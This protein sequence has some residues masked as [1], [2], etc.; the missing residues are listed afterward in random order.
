MFCSPLNHFYFHFDRFQY[1]YDS[2][3]KNSNTFNNTH[4]YIIMIPT[5]F[6]F[7]Q[8]QC[9]TNS[10]K[11]ICQCQ[12]LENVFAYVLDHL[13]RPDTVCPCGH[14][15]H[16]LTRF[17]FFEDIH[18]VWI[19]TSCVITQLIKHTQYAECAPNPSI[20]INVVF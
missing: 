3:Y 12:T 2:R 19:P 10:Q 5:N 4:R 16:I 1:L 17:F 9:R 7:I 20:R 18:V 11:N 13:F 8:P 15:L 6:F 14:I